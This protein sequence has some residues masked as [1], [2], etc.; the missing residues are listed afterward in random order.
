MKFIKHTLALLTCALAAGAASAAT[1]QIKFDNPIFNGSG[2]DNVNVKFANAGSDT[3]YTTEYVS[4]GRFQGTASNVVGVSESIFFDGLNDVYMYCYD[5][6]QSINH[7]QSLSYNINSYA[8]NART[9]DFIGA[10]NKVLS[11]DQSVIDPYAW[12]HGVTASQGAAIQL[13][14]WESKYESAGWDLGG[15]TFSASDLE[16]ATINSWISFRDAID[17]SSAVDGKYVMTL[18]NATYQ[19][20]IAGDPPANVPEPGSLALIGAALA[21]LAFTRRRKPSLV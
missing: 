16:Q 7:G 1:V 20:M 13:G 15:G 4:A 8:P 5:I 9:L 10:V 2:Y 18:S 11:P 19:D 17:N 14:L 12:L 6:Y 21:G 3:A